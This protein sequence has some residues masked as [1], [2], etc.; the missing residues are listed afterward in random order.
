MNS[1]VRLNLISSNEGVFFSNTSFLEICWDPLDSKFHEKF[2]ARLDLDQATTLQAFAFST[3]RDSIS[4]A[5]RLNL[6]GPL[7]AVELCLD[8]GK[9]VEGPALPCKI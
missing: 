2:P 7:L 1:L 3:V 4:A 5:V 9:E 6:L 8:F